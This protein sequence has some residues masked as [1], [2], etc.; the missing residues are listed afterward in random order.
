MQPEQQNQTPAPNNIP[1]YLGMEQVTN[2]AVAKRKNRKKMVIVLLF[3]VLTTVFIFVSIVL[4]LLLQ[5]NT[6]QERFYGAL[7]KQMQVSYIKRDIELKKKDGSMTIAIAT[8]T[9]DP[10]QTKSDIRTTASSKGKAVLDMQTIVLNNERYMFSI[11]STVQQASLGDLEK[12]QWY[13][14]PFHAADSKEVGYWI[15]ETKSPLVLNSIQGLVPTGNFTSDQ[16]SQLLDYIRLND[17]YHISDIQ[18]RSDKNT[19][20]T[21]YTIRLDID[22]LNE[23]NA[24]IVKLLG[25]SP[26]LVIQKPYP[27]YQETIFW[28]NETTGMLAELTYNSGKSKDGIDVRQTTAFTYPDKLSISSPARVEEVSF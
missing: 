27:E 20:L 12:N 3:L 5:Q 15:D 23:L 14:A 11:Q 6:P 17:V 9:S 22:K 21:G 1:D 4:Y 24:Q 13:S 2:S 10:K 7:D 16:R 18:T 8:D 25:L 28:V 19:K 26:T